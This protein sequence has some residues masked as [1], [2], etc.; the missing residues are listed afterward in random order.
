VDNGGGLSY[1][2]ATDSRTGAV[3]DPSS[4]AVGVR[5]NF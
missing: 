2:G 5:H 1:F 4:F 3:L